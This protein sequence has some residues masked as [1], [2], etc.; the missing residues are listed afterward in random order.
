MCVRAL[1]A[2]SNIYVNAALPRATL[3]L[4]RDRGLRVCE[5]QFVLQIKAELCVCRLLFRHWFE[6]Q[7]VFVFAFELLVL[8]QVAVAQCV[9]RVDFR[10]T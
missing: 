5:G 7:L 9:I 2:E 10:L 1:L 4:P 8:F 6:S 3:V